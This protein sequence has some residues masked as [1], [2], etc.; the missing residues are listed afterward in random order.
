MSKALAVVPEHAGLA[1]IVQE[2]TPGACCATES[3]LISGLTA[4]AKDDSPTFRQ[5]GSIGSRFDA[6]RLR[7][8]GE[9]G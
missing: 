5:G 7:G 2:L 3:A 4:R 9:R 1:A 8:D 6:S